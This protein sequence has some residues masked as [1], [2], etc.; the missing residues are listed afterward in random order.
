MVAGLL[1]TLSTLSPL[2][3]ARQTAPDESLIIG[4][5]EHNDS[6]GKKWHNVRVAFQKEGGRWKTYPTDFNTEQELAGSVNSYPAEVAWTVCSDG[7]SA[8]SLT[9][10]NPESVRSYKDVGTHQISSKGSVPTVGQP[11]ELFSGWPG[12]RTYRPLVLSSGTTCAD[13]GV[14]RPA[15]PDAA[16]LDAVRDYLRREHNVPA[17]KMSK[18]KVTPNKSYGSQT[19]GAKLVSVNIAGAEVIPASGEDDQNMD[20]WFYV[21]GKEVRFLGS[22]MLLV[23]AGDYDGDGKEEAVFKVQRY[24]NDGYLLFHDGFKNKLEFSWS[25]H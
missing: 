16:D 14:W 23:D 4:L 3:T 18:A 2:S 24:N 25:Y 5:L 7:R 21:A 15:K 6:E 19:R 13:P 9:S 22:N 12:G 11:S 1:I 10:K 20:V 8:G 17:A